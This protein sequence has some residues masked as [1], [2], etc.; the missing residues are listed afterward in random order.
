MIGIHM[1]Y[2]TK[3]VVG[4]NEAHDGS[5]QQCNSRGHYCQIVEGQREEVDGHIGKATLGVSGRRV[6]HRMDGRLQPWYH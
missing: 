5:R 3:D 4:Q 1:M 6:S 2:Y